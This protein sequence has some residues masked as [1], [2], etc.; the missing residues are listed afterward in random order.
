MTGVQTC[1]LPI[2]E[3]QHLPG[4]SFFIRAMFDHQAENPNELSFHKDDILFVDNTMFNGVPGLW[5]A[6]IVNEEGLQKQCGAIP[7][8]YK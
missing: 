6:W 7:S 8:K 1:A 5:R 2:Y 4:D 3:I